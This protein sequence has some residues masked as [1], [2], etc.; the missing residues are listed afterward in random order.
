MFRSDNTL[1]AT[2]EVM[3]A[4]AEAAAQAPSPYGE[5]ALDR[6]LHTTLQ[7]C[8]EHEV[9]VF[10]V[11]TGT[12]ANALAL[13]TLCPPWGAIYCHPEAHIHC[14]ECGAPEQATGGAKLVLVDGDAGKIEPARLQRAIFGRD[15]VH[16]VQPALLSLSQSTECGTVYQPDA[17]AELCALAHANQLLVHLDGA[18]LA[19]AIAT[20]GCSPADLT[21]RAGVDVLTLGF[22]K[23][24]ALC[25]ELILFFNPEHCQSLA[26]RRKRAGHLL[27]KSWFVSVQVQALLAENRWLHQAQHANAMATRLA[28]GLTALGYPPLWPCQANAVF[29]ALPAA[30]AA[31]ARDIGAV[32]YDWPAHTD[33]VRLVCSL[34]T[35]PAEVDAFLAAVRRATPAP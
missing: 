3:T 33:L 23:N 21:W 15:N 34:R 10:S 8:F 17:L 20:L 24:G 31:S 14:D 1:G 7:Q 26:F 19:N 6:A 11:A 16:R 30:V 32:F 25:A 18:R 9:A 28:Q 5:D 27:S 22:T 29:V 13:A 12:A 4:L 35:T 2:P